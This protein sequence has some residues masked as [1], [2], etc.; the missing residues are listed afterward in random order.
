MS[1]DRIYIHCK[2][3]DDTL[4]LMKYYPARAYGLHSKETNEWMEAH[5]NGTNDD[6]LTVHDK[7][8]GDFLPTGAEL[9]DIWTEGDF[10]EDSGGA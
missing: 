9:F 4:L 5:I 2:Q 6:G 10:P 3:C 7:S 8:G 1:N